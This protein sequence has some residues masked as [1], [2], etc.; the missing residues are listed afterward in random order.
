MGRGFSSRDDLALPDFVSGRFEDGSC[1]FR[2]ADPPRSVRGLVWVIGPLICGTGHVFG[3]DG[4]GSGSVLTERFSPPFEEK[5]PISTFF[6]RLADFF[7]PRQN[8]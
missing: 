3:V 5:I 8:S 7:Q 6:S 4:S 1:V 2:P